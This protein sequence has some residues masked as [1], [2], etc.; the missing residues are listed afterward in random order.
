MGESNKAWGDLNDETRLAIDNY[1]NISKWNDNLFHNYLYNLQI[2]ETK[3]VTLELLSQQYPFDFSKMNIN[4]IKCIHKS[5]KGHINELSWS[6]PIIKAAISL[7]NT[8][9][10]KNSQNY[11]TDI[12]H[13]IDI[14]IQ[15]T[16]LFSDEL[17]EI[18]KERIFDIATI[19]KLEQICHDIIEYTQ[20]NMNYR[21]D[22]FKEDMNNFEKE[23]RK[24]SN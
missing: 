10:D 6:I 12:I 22:K 17:I 15:E 5:S 1:K 13:W 8:L 16:E 2:P 21:W 18:Q 7:M 14:I 9:R 19:N 4:D 3:K 24:K 11:A 23:F 20:S